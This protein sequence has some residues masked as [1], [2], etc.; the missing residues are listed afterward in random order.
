MLFVGHLVNLNRKSTIIHSYISAIRSVLAKDGVIL[1]ED[2][3]LL[4]SLMK[5]CHLKND[6]VI[7]RL[8]ICYGVLNLMLK[9]IPD[10]YR[11]SQVYLIA[12]Y[13]ALFITAY[14]GLFRI[15]ELTKGEHTVKAKDVHE[16]INKDKLMFVLHT[17]KTHGKDRKPQVIK[18]DSIGKLPAKRYG[19]SPYCPLQFLQEYINLRGDSDYR[20]EQFFVF[21]DRSPVR[22]NHARKIMK[23][24]LQIIGLD[25]AYYSF[26]SIHAGRAVDLLNVHKLS[27]ETIR[28]IGRWRSTAIYTYLKY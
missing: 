16:G 21:R 13:R 18:I 23:K 1:N 19:T 28:K 7:T 11:D 20:E 17:S 22:P 24:L 3:V 8:P 6:T 12:M 5:A 26:H 4:S 27:I 14:Y 10:L 9:Y 2:K 15:G 25:S